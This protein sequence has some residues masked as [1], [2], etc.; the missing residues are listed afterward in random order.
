MAT[1]GSGQHSHVGVCVSVCMHKYKT[2]ELYMCEIQLFS[3]IRSSS[4]LFLLSGRRRLPWLQGRHGHQ[5][6]PGEL[7]SMC[8]TSRKVK[9]KK[10]EEKKHFK[11]TITSA[12][13]SGSRL[14][15]GWPLFTT[16]YGSTFLSPVELWVMSKHKVLFWLPAVSLCQCDGVYVSSL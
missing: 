11:T 2:N 9:K 16:P 4:F 14:C 3:F 1:R 15:R 8:H 12:V 10:E 6:W 5:G 7:L 13:C